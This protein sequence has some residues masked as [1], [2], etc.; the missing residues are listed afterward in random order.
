MKRLLTGFLSA[1]LLL[2]V[3]LLAACGGGSKD[4]LPHDS[5][6]AD[7]GDSNASGAVLPGDDTASEPGQVTFPERDYGM[8]P[9]RILCTTQCEEIYDPD[10]DNHETVVTGASFRCNSLAEE[11]FG[12]E[13]NFRAMEGRSVGRDAFSGEVRISSMD[14][15]TTYD[16]IIGQTYY[17]MAIALEGLYFNMASSPY[18][19]LNENWYDKELINDNIMI[20]NKLYAASGDY[21]VSQISTMMGLYYNKT[22]YTNY[23]LEET[24]MEGTDLYDSVR[25]RTWTYEKLKEMTVSVYEDED[26]S[27]TVTSGDV[28]GFIG[29]THAP[30]C[31]LI[32]SDTPYTERDELGDIS[33][34]NYFNAHLVDVFDTYFGF[35]NNE[36][37]VYYVASDEGL[38]ETFCNSQALFCCHAVEYMAKEVVRGSFINYGLV[39]F[40]LYNEDQT[41]YYTSNI[42]WE[43]ANIPKSCDTERAAIL[44]DFLNYV[45]CT[46]FTPQYFDVV[47]STQVSPSEDDTEM[48]Q[49]I[50]DCVR[51][52]F[53]TFYQTQLGVSYS[54]N[55]Y[56]DVKALIRRG[57]TGIASWWES[58]RE[59]YRSALVDLMDLYFYYL[60]EE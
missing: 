24:V 35:F 14:P 49:L 17:T 22:I 7:E 29:N 9:F 34:D 13:L 31:A 30:Q 46:R 36:Q 45:Y 27:G 25:G 58:N 11:T 4:P 41:S 42:R 5:T 18:I 47:L 21:V 8:K 6:A 60:D 59:T 15:S 16:L 54:D 38:I 50:R 56:I 37:S 53:A 40:P 26:H 2:S 33:L 48:L 32:G 1:L 51:F 23:H 12:I 44:F 28:F 57:D 43:I 10:P 3:L 39:P 20:N 52:D 19:R 55:I